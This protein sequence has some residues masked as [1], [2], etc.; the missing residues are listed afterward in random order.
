MKTYIF[1]RQFSKI[2]NTSGYIHQKNITAKLFKDNIYSSILY[3]YNLVTLINSMFLITKNFDTIVFVGP[4][5]HTF[6]MNKPPS[7]L[8]E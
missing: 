8:N 6:L 5:P 4:N 1:K 7:T 3:D 2:L